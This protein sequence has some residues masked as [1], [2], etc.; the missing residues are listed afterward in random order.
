MEPADLESRARSAYERGRGVF[1]FRGALFLLPLALLMVLLGPRPWLSFALGLLVLLTAS[2]FRFRGGI[3]ARALPSGVAA[4]VLAWAFPVLARGSALFCPSGLGAVL[5]LGGAVTGGFLGGI[6]IASRARRHEAGRDV[7]L[8]SASWVAVLIGISG[9][10][11]AGG[12][13]VLGMATGFLAG[14]SPA[15][16]LARSH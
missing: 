3:P 5:C 7:F 12:A 10:L 2:A 15:F 1:A 16:L 4:G 11:A 6:L 14:A 9:C 13:G 8:A